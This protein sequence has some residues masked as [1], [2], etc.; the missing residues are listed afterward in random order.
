[1]SRAFG[2]WQPSLNSAAP[3]ALGASTSRVPRRHWRLATIREFRG[4]FG[5]WQPFGSSAAPLALGNQS[6]ISPRLWHPAPRVPLLLTFNFSVF[7]SNFPHV[8]PRGLHRPQHAPR[9]GVRP[10]APSPRGIWV[11]G[12]DFS[13]APAICKPCRALAGKSPTP[14]FDGRNMSICPTD[15]ERSP[16]LARR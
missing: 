5:A 7:T 13:Y 15:S 3:F 1:M 11:P 16:D 10:Y 2:A 12:A 14:S 6:G 9:H 8:P 4:A